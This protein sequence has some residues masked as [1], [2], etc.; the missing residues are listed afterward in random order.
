MTFCFALKLLSVTFQVFCLELESKLLIA[1]KSMKTCGMTV[2]RCSGY[3]NANHRLYFCLMHDIRFCMSFVYIRFGNSGRFSVETI[4]SLLLKSFF[5]VVQSY[6]STVLMIW[7]NEGWSIWFI[8]ASP[9]SLTEGW[10]IWSFSLRSLWFLTKVDQYDFSWRTLCSFIR[11][12][13][14]CGR[15]VH[16]IFFLFT[17]VWY[18]L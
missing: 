16:A 11:S 3:D 1:Q 4:Y 6:I 2:L 10:S 5:I 18:V 12:A 14:L 7:M 15:F 13:V 17:S 8:I 9:L